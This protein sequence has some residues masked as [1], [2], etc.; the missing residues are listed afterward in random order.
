[1]ARRFHGPALRARRQAAG[2]RREH[3][4]IAI[5]RSVPSIAGYERSEVN[6]SVEALA[7]IADLLGCRIDDFFADVEADAGDS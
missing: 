7:R 2:L 5:D 1:M 6:P 4:A 3:V